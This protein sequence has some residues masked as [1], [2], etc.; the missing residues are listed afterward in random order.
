MVFWLLKRFLL[1]EKFYTLIKAIEHGFHGTQFTFFSH[2][3]LSV[4]LSDVNFRVNLAMHHQ[5]YLEGSTLFLYVFAYYAHFY[6]LRQEVLWPYGYAKV[7]QSTYQPLEIKTH[8]VR[9]DLIDYW[10]YSNATDVWKYCKICLARIE[11]RT[12][13]D[14]FCEKL[15]CFERSDEFLIWR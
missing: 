2:F 4:S 10:M 14:H 3:S 9:N 15:F 7:F 1:Q 8:F 13:L 11:S 6:C 12:W 5:P